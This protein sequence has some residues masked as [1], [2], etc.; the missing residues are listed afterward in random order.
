MWTCN[1]D[2]KRKSLK[3]DK[4]KVLIIYVHQIIIILMVGEILPV[5]VLILFVY[6]PGGENMADKKDYKDLL[7]Q[8]D[9]GKFFQ[10]IQDAACKRAVEGK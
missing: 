7:R 5:R 1:N 4:T 2:N 3:N 10:I 9:P 8:K 6:L